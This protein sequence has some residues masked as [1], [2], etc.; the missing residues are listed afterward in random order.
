KPAV[1]GEECHAVTQLLQAIE[2]ITEPQ[3]A[4]ILVRLGRV[5]IDYQYQAFESMVT[6]TANLALVVRID[7]GCRVSLQFLLPSLQELAAVDLLVALGATVQ[8]S[9]GGD[10]LKVDDARRG[11]VTNL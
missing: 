9:A 2:N 4:G 8:V 10:A 7:N 3:A 11:L 5:S 1:V 6:G